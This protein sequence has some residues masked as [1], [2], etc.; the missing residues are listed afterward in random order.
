MRRFEGQATDIKTP[1]AGN[2]L[3]RNPSKDKSA[4]QPKPSKE[5]VDQGNDEST[6]IQITVATLHPIT[7]PLEVDS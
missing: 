6:R 7:K 4:R 1:I 2:M 3:N 5:A